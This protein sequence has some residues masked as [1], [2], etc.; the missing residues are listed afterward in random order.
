MARR[1]AG[2]LIFGAFM[3]ALAC[4]WLLAA[5][6]WAGEWQPLSDCRLRDSP[7]NDGDSFHVTHGGKEYIF[8][9]CYVDTPETRAL[10]AYTERTTAQARYFGI[11]KSTLFKIAAQASAFTRQTLNRP[12]TV[13]TDWT[14]ARG[15]SQ[16]P[17][18]FGIIQTSGQDLAELLV[19][20]GFSRVY[21]YSPD[22]PDGTPAAGYRAKLKQLEVRAFAEKAGAWA[23]SKRKKP[24]KFSRSSRAHASPAAPS[25]QA[26]PHVPAI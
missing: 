4:L 22:R 1:D 9:L 20:R 7:F 10:R 2:G 5:P 12:F 3:R 6:L 16:Q 23:E 25:P 11:K 19:A 26:T 8:R 17:R 18:F 15:N 24:P 21:G 14:D 13:W